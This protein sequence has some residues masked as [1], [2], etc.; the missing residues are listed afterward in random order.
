[1]DAV[2]VVWRRAGVAAWIRLVDV[3]D[4]RLGER[5]ALLVEMAGQHDAGAHPEV[6]R[7][8]HPRR[9]RPWPARR[10]TRPFWVPAGIAQEQRPAA[11]RDDA[12]LPTQ[13]RLT[14]GQRQVHDE[15]GAVALKTGCAATWT[16]M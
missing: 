5:P 8:H 12:H 1:M 9:G 6:A 15:V 14:E 10:M 13:E 16:V 4:E 7:D 11:Q 3:V 2:L